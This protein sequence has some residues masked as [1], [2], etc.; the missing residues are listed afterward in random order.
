MAPTQTRTS[1]RPGSAADTYA[2]I[3]RGENPHVAFGDFLDDW[4]RTPVDERASLVAQPI[5][6]AG[7]GAATRRWAALLAAAV[8][9]LCVTD[10]LHAP[11]WVGR[12]EYRLPEPWFLVPGTALRAWLLV[13][14]PVPF[15]MR[16]IF[17]G[18]TML[19]RS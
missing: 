17:G 1:Y 6:D 3:T 11:S 7:T 9:Q 15:K 16:N 2:R 4:R 19:T 13:S 12:E 10:D 5:G 8:E 14:T 18:D